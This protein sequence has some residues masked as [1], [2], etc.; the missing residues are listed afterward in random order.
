MQISIGFAN[1]NYG[2]GDAWVNMP[3]SVHQMVPWTNIKASSP[4]AVVAATDAETRKAGTSDRI[5]KRLQPICFS[6]VEAKLIIHHICW[7]IRCGGNSLKVCRGNLIC[8]LR[9]LLCQSLQ[10]ALPGASGTVKP[11]SNHQSGRE[12]TSSFSPTNGM[13]E[14]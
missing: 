11:G 2:Q 1:C 9:R 5:R 14:Q 7:R 12:F 10:H 6:L 3:N 8:R 4:E 13:N